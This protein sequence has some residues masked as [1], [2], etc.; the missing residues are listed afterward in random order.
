MIPPDDRLRATLA[1]CIVSA[2]G[3][4]LADL[5]AAL[6]ISIPAVREGLSVLTD[7]LG[8]VGLRI[9][10]DGVTVRVAPPGF[11]H[12]AVAALTRVKT[13]P[14]LSEEQMTI[15]CV[16]AYA[17]SATRRRIAELRGEDCETVLRRMVSLRL[18]EAS[19]DDERPRAQPLPGHC[20]GVGGLGTRRW[21][22]SSRQSPG[23]SA[24][25]SCARL[26]SWARRG[27]ALFPI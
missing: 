5:A 18:L 1:A 19:R 16:V 20:E 6:G 10:E 7:R 13:V 26:S 14:Q 4:G 12:H 11:A 27:P 24:A 22:R 8:R 17:G 3:A 15:L 21:R 23:S 2:G 25:R 9:V